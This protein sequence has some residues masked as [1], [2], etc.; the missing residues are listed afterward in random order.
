[1]RAATVVSTMAALVLSCS[2]RSA[3]E[4]AAADLVE[5]QLERRCRILRIAGA[6]GDD[7][8]VL[9]AVDRRTLVADAVD[10]ERE[11]FYRLVRI[12]AGAEPH[13]ELPAERLE[14]STAPEHGLTRVRVGDRDE[15][16]LVVQDGVAVPV[17]DD[18]G[19]VGRER[20]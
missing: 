11:R 1:M 3:V 9:V 18:L 2:G 8:G 16:A 6:V 12:D 19:R 14:I 17:S 4:L 10:G 7:V 20:S 5:R 13:D 15:V